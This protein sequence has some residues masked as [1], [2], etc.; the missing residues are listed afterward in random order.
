M[1]IGLE[2]LFAGTCHISTDHN[3]KHYVVSGTKS[4]SKRGFL[5]IDTRRKN[6]WYGEQPDSF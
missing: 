5:F 6:R 2:I 4:R 1:Q 3:V